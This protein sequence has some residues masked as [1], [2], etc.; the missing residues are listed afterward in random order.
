MTPSMGELGRPG[1]KSGGVRKRTCKLGRGSRDRWT[2]G[3]SNKGGIGLG[4][5]DETDEAKQ[6]S[7]ETK[8][9]IDW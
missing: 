5:R 4:G 7:W 2:K 6:K 1:Q 3:L 9:S 8:T